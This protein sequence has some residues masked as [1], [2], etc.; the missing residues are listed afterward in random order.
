LPLGHALLHADMMRMHMAL[1]TILSVLIQISVQCGASPGRSSTQEHEAY[2][3]SEIIAQHTTLP[4]HVFGPPATMPTPGTPAWS[5]RLWP[6]P[7]RHPPPQHIVC[8]AFCGER[9]CP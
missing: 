7:P 8:C 6:R 3:E 5:G 1:Q 2:D 9:W 4:G